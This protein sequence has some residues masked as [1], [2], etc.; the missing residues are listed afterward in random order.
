MITSGIPHMA[1]GWVRKF[2]GNLFNSEPE[3][4]YVLRLRLSSSQNADFHS[5]LM[6]L[7]F[8]HPFGAQTETISHSML[9]DLS[10]FIL[11]SSM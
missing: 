11:H 1:E 7:D 3:N 2:A 6:D 9:H 8:M 5:C 4:S 10:Y